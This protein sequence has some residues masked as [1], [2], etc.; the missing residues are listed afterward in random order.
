MPKLHLSF[1]NRIRRKDIRSEREWIWHNEAKEGQWGRRGA[2]GMY[3]GI[4]GKGYYKRTK[5]IE[6]RSRSHY[7]LVYSFAIFYLIGLQL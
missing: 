6:A 2:N 1:P 5:E 4:G 7:F 3:R